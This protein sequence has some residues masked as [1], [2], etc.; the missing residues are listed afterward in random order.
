MAKI[1]LDQ[2]PSPALPRRFLLSA[3]LWGMVAGA[4]LVSDGALTLQT[5]WAP[6]TLALALVHAFT[7]GVLGNAM[8]GSL[9]QFPAAA[10]LARACPASPHLPRTVLRTGVHVVRRW[11]RRSS[12]NCAP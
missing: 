9:L 10:R 6:A 4:L 8:F 5:R 12:S 3:P 7:L 1:A 2:M 11:H